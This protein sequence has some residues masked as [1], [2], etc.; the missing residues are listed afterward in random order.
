MGFSDLLSSGRGP[1]VIGTLIALLVLVGF[2]SLYMFAFDEGMQGGKK[3]IHA[4]VRDQGISIDSSKTEIANYRKQLDDVAHRKEHSQELDTLKVQAEHIAARL[5]EVTEGH[6]AATADAEGARKKWEDYKDAYRAAE[7]AKAK[8]EKLGD[9]TSLAGVTYHD[10]T[11]REVNHKEMKITDSTGPKS[12]DSKLLP[13]ALQDRFQFDVEK[14]KAAEVEQNEGEEIHRKKVEYAETLEKRDDKGMLLAT[15]NRDI[16]NAAAAIKKANEDVEGWR[17][18]IGRQRGL[19]SAEKSKKISKAP[20]MEADLRRMQAQADENKNSI[21]RLQGVK[22][23][24]QNKLRT[25]E[26]EISALNA[27]LPKIGKELADLRAAKA[28]KTE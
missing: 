2:G 27:E 7:W 13:L 16:Q 15:M 21:P 9:V 25:L 5:A 22:T 18:K 23:D 4:V 3:T 10:V 6:A 1:G 8:G 19:I 14:K 26:Q 20:Q 17:V 12:I 28:P 11:V 24:L